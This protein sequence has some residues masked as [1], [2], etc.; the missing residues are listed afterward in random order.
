MDFFVSRCDRR[1]IVKHIGAADTCRHDILLA[2]F[3]VKGLGIRPDHLRTA[4][5][6]QRKIFV[7]REAHQLLIGTAELLLRRAESKAFECS[8]GMPGL[9][10][11]CLRPQRNAADQRG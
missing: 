3:H 6:H 5:R 7:K 4:D 1:L 8:A 11:L 9:D 10:D 2:F